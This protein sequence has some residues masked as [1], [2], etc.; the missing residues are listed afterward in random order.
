MTNYYVYFSSCKKSMT[1]IYSVH[2]PLPWRT[3]VIFCDW[4]HLLQVGR[5]SLLNGLQH[6][7][8]PEISQLVQTHHLLQPLQ[9]NVLRTIVHVEHLH[10]LLRQLRQLL[11]FIRLT[12]IF[13]FDSMLELTLTSNWSC[14][15]RLT[16]SIIISKMPSKLG[17][18]GGLKCH[19]IC[20]LFIGCYKISNII[21]DN[22]HWYSPSIVH[23]AEPFKNAAVSNPNVI[24]KWTSLDDKHV[25]RD[26][27][28]FCFEFSLIHVLSNMALQN[29]Y[30]HY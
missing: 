23:S 1:Y 3:V 20:W 12:A 27:S 14:T 18:N 13:S 22:F 24:S 6:Y 5:S 30:Q 9:R 7:H 2:S 19:F 29:E 16:D 4:L 26:T 28:I 21:C 25:K 11:H 8:R 15:S 10:L 17:G